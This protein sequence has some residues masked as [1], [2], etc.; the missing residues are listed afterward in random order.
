MRRSDRTIYIVR[1]GATKFNAEAG[2]SVDRE[3]GWSDVR[4]TEEG[5]QEARKAGAALKS[6][7][8]TAIVSSD[9]E[10]AKETAQIIGGIIGIKP[11]FSF[12]LRPWN[13]GDFTGEDLKE[14]NPQ[15]CAYAKTADKPVPG[16]ESFNAFKMRAFQG[17][18]EAVRKHPDPLL[19]VCHHRVERLIA[20]WCKAGEPASHAINLN[21][22]LEQGDPPGGIIILHTSE[23]ALGGKGGDSSAG[24]LSHATVHF[25]H[26][27]GKDR[28]GNCKAFIGTN[29]CKKVVPP[30][31]AD[32]WCAVGVSKTD[33]H[34]FDPRGEAIEAKGGLMPKPEKSDMKPRRFGALA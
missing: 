3:R 7:G 34:R 32:D 28:C 25:G 13:L 5:R 17:V 8:L 19:I 15:I 9:L 6:K 16:G 24:K 26:A 10:R 2:V 11:E 20:G 23:A 4:L 22:F 14:A 1:H 33:G 27:K 31:D 30:I 29:Q 21:T 12:K 18:D